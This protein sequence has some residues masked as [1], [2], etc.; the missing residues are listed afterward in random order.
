[1]RTYLDSDIRSKEMKKWDNITKRMEPVRITEGGHILKG[2]SFVEYVERTIEGNRKA[3]KDKKYRIIDEK[4]INVSWPG[5]KATGSWDEIRKLLSTPW[6]EARELIDWYIEEVRKFPLPE[7]HSIRRVMKW[8]DNEG[9]IS[10]DKAL[11]GEPEFY[12]KGVRHK[13]KGP[14]QIVLLTNLDQPGNVNK[15]GIFHRSVATIVLADILE[16]K[17]YGVEIWAWCAGGYVF[18]KPNHFQFNALQ[19]KKSDQPVDKETL[20]NVLSAWFT[21][22]IIWGSWNANPVNPVSIGY[23][24]YA[25]HKLSKSRDCYLPDKQEDKEICKMFTHIEPDENQSQTYLIP[26]ITAGYGWNYQQNKMDVV[27]EGSIKG[28]GMAARIAGCCAE[29]L[30]MII[31]RESDPST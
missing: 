10:S 23:A 22:Y 16:S 8:N 3:E 5:R 18:P 31:D 24:M 26:R 17:G 4:R 2:T 9:D 12:R 15:S 19:V 29:I 7:P 20:A 13:I 1:M 28:P 6:P 27:N 14:S 11:L 25:D 30:Q 21:Y